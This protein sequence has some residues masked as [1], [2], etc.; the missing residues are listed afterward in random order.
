MVLST[1]VLTFDNFGGLETHLQVLLTHY[2]ETATKC[3]E[4]LG[5][6]LRSKPDT[7]DDKWTQEYSQALAGAGGKKAKPDK[8][9]GKKED[10]KAGGKKGEDLDWIDFDPFSIFIGAEVKGMAELYFD[11]INQ[12]DETVRKLELAMNTLQTLK[13]KATSSGSVALIV[14]MV[15]DIP[16]KVVVKPAAANASGK[17]VAS[18]SFALP[19]AAP[20]VRPKVQL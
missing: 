17:T 18:F 12:V 8:K 20:V 7:K 15:N 9:E 10:K 11:V 1:Q 5:E 16:T 19:A 13:G 3:R 14:S 6:I 4:H 2:K